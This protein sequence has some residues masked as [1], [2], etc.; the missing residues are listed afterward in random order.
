MAG[1]PDDIEALR[2]A[3][4]K[5]EIELVAERAARL[6][7]EAKASSIDALIASLK[8]QIEKL[9]RELYGQRSERKARLLDQMELELEDLEVSATEDELK[10]EMAAS[11]TTDVKAFTRKKPSRKPFPE[12]L[13]RERVVIPGPTSCD[14][15]GSEKLAK[16]GEDITETLE[17]IPRQWKVIQYVREKFTCRH[18]ESIS[19]PPAPY[20][21]VMQVL[22]SPIYAGAYAFGRTCYRTNVVDSRARKTNGHWRAM[23]DWGALLKDNHPG[24]ITWEAFE[25]NQRMIQEN[26]HMQ[27]RTS[28]KAARGGRA[29]V[30]GLVR[31]G[32]CGRMMRVFYGMR[33][34]H[35]HRY[36]CRGDDAYV[37]AGLCI[38]I[39]G[40]RID[41]AIAVQI[42]D[43][44]S[45]RAVDAALHAADQMTKAAAEVHEAVERELEEAR[46]EASLA[47]RRYEL[48]DPAKRHVA[49]ELEARWNAALERVDALERRI[50]DMEAEAVARPKIDREV[51]M[52]LAQDLPAVWNAPTTDARVKQRLVRV[53]IHEV[54]IDL[55]DAAHEAVV[56]IH[57]AG[58]RHTEIR[59]PRIKSGHYHAANQRPSAVEVMRRLGG[60][61]PDRQLAVTMNRMRCK[62]DDGES[63]TTVRVREFRERLGIVP[64]D[65]DTAE[66]TISVDATATRLGICVGSVH[67]LIKDGVL[68]AEQVM[69]SA[70]WKV[71]VAA[72]DTKAVRI[73]VREI[74]ARRPNNFHVLQDNKTL[75]LPG[76]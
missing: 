67:K 3:L 17:V 29:L 11:E 18:C 66:E 1:P 35:A 51:L 27:K 73:G 28:R 54:V 57:W 38:G 70:P 56:V 71:P 31:C 21:T 43:A 55:D 20:H 13:P 25:E 72:L 4:A 65:P 6:A 24:Y 53:L 61:W 32:R 49:R 68:P 8:L 50:V 22:R 26:A 63:W 58:G 47:S 19:Q 64:F 45:D 33:S 48:V 7:A 41:R 44:V 76:I 14:C 39:G 2:A 59:V 37:G 9:R 34:G 36:Q 15:C 46:Y 5:A 74:I 23:K 60:Q 16:L 69:H 10:A 42:L 30:T 12:H 75:P 62:T 40:V 52:Q